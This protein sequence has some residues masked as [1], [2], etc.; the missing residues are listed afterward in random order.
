MK[1]QDLWC[2]KEARAESS[3]K[4]DVSGWWTE[5]GGVHPNSFAV[6]CLKLTQT[7]LARLDDVLLLVL[8]LLRECKVI[9]RRYRES[10]GGDGKR[11]GEDSG[12]GDELHGL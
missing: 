10:S 7:G 2:R 1:P 12:D 9:H 5:W 8:I 3:S 4:V 6:A 11:R